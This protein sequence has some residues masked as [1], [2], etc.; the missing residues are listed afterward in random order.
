MAPGRAVRLFGVR[1]L[2]LPEWESI[3]AL[4]TGRKG[5]FLPP[6]R[7]LGGGGEGKGG[8]GRGGREGGEDGAG[9]GRACASR[10][11]AAGLALSQSLW[12]MLQP[13]GQGN[14]FGLGL[15]G[16]GQEGDGEGGWGG[17]SRR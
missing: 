8:Q 6:Q 15:R 12:T 10:A 13:R 1:G 11:W 7:R 16:G 17:G 5:F 9:G 14:S 2:F 4:L 3:W